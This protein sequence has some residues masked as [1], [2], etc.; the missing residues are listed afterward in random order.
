MT[1]KEKVI[2]I[3][4]Q[5]LK[6]HRARF[7]NHFFVGEQG[8]KYLAY[9]TRYLLEEYLNIPVKDI[10]KRVKA[11]ILWNH[12]LRPPA[13][14]FGWNFLDVIQN[15]YPGKF[16]PW[17]FRQVSNH[18]WCGTGG[19]TRAIETVK[20]VIEVKC[21]IPHQEI[22]QK[23]NHHFFRERGLLGIIRLFNDSPYRVINAIYPDQFHPWQFSNVPMNYWKNPIHVKQRMDV[24]LFEEIGFSSY[25]EAIKNLRKKYFFQYRLTGLF[26]MA[27]DSR[28]YKVK[29]WIAKQIIRKEDTGEKLIIGSLLR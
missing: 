29:E 26:Q 3:Y 1:E 18:Y 21:N 8:K 15:A 11:E 6:G 10:S 28:L 23:I 12:R 13:Q 22:P 17:E 14:F 20:Y 4:R 9:L 19:R 2:D 5:I 27:F 24:L 16:Q 7:P 25:Q